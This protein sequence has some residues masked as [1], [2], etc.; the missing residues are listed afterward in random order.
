[1]YGSWGVNLLPVYEIEGETQ[2]HRNKSKDNNGQAAGQEHVTEGGHLE[3]EK[4][5]LLL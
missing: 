1:M 2:A 4:E 3:K 5:V